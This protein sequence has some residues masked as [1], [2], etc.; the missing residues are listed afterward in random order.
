MAG[1]VAGWSYRIMAGRRTKLTPEKI[2]G[3]T[4]AVQAGHYFVTACKLN[5]ISES[6]GYEW[7]ARGQGTHP[8]PKTALYARFAEAVEKATAEAESRALVTIQKAALGGAPVVRSKRTKTT[9]R[10]LKDGT[11]ET[12][13]NSEDIEELTPPNWTAAA[14]YLER[15]FPDRW[16]KKQKLEH[17]GPGGGPIQTQTTAVDL[18]KLSK[19]E[20]EALERMA[21]SAVPDDDEDGDE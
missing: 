10:T 5:G 2:E 9:T 13:T 18:S 12:V 17:S 7:L 20:L 14:W 8:R 21:L 11:V 3:I 16:A 6:V 1:W 15:K 4:R 19:E